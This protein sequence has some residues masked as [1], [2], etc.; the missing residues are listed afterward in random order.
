[1]LTPALGSVSTGVSTVRFLCYV[2]TGAT[3]A[4]GSVSTGVSTGAIRILPYVMT[5]ATPALGSVSTGVSTGAIILD[6]F[7]M[8]YPVL[9][10][11]CDLLA[12]VLAPV[13]FF[14]ML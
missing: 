5:G 1:M 9:P 8:L 12:P 3:P 11:H 10:R 6:F 2:I 7:V 4:L 14:V 13:L